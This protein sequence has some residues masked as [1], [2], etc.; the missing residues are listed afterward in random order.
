MINLIL[1]GPPGCGKG[2]QA[3]NLVNRY[4]LLHISTGDMF[5]AEIG[6]N[7][8]LGIEAKSY[9]NKG[10][11]VPDSVTIKMLAKKM[12]EHPNV[13]G[14]LLDGF[15]RTIPQ[16]QALDTLFE[17]RGESI[18]QLIA[19]QVDEDEL[20]R[21]LLK[22]GEMSERADDRNEEIIRNRFSVYN[23]QTTP[24]AEYYAEQDKTAK[25]DGTGSIADVTERLY[26]AIESVMV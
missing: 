8:P 11:L 18:T 22:R 1:F 16:A 2:T 7:T 3:E 20:T 15:P 17:E 19:L 13:K 24:V 21:R 6:G 25:I 5:R 4:N 12:S 10:E 23:E 9:I 14:F 26:S